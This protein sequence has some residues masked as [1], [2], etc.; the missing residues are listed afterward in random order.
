MARGR[1]VSRS[2]NTNARLEA[3]P[4]EIADF[5][6]RLIVETDV[7]G[8][9]RGK[10][11]SLKENLYELRSNVTPR[12]INGWLN[13]LAESKDTETGLGLVE[14][15]RAERRECL[16]LPGFEKH[17]KGLNKRREAPS[18]IPE[19]PAEL[20]KLARKN[21]V[22]A[23]GAEDGKPKAQVKTDDIKVASMVRYY[24]KMTRRTLGT[25]DLQRVI[26]FADEYDEAWFRKGVDEVVAS[27]EP[28]NSPM[29]YIGR[30]LENWKV[31]GGV[32][33]AQP[34]KRAAAGGGDEDY[35]DA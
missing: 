6:K 2:I 26:E 4:I 35:E 9:I 10:S 34:R 28:V 3:M 29:A 33:A 18:Q 31:G 30:C 20:L 7:E 15:Y 22:A 8:R 16:W 5:F 32:T 1:F 12:R 17:Q 25:G 23:K 21:L 11:E 27:P 13:R 24:E 14:V 19:P